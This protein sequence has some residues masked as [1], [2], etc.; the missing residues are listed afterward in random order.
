LHF[1]QRVS[2]IDYFQSHLLHATFDAGFGE[3]GG[4]LGRGVIGNYGQV[5]IAEAVIGHVAL[6]QL[7]GVLFTTVLAGAV[8]FCFLDLG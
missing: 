3:R 5:G 1:I 6:I 7:R 2:T 8:L 4:H